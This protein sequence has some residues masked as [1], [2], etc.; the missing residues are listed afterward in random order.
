MNKHCEN[1]IIIVKSFAYRRLTKII[2]IKGTLIFFLGGF[3]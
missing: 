2:K 1:P 3:I